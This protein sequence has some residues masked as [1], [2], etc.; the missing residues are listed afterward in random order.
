MEIEVSGSSIEVS[1]VSRQKTK[2]KSQ[3]GCCI[4]RFLPSVFLTSEP[5][6]LAIETS[7]RQLWRLYRTAQ[8]LTVQKKKRKHHEHTGESISGLLPG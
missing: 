4:L 7:S 3:I 6:K 1:A 2:Y 8:A 5:L